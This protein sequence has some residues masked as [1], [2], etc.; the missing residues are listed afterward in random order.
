MVF[1]WTTDRCER[2]NIPD[3]PAR[4]FRDASGQVQQ[5]ISHQNNYR[6]VGPDL[7]NV[8]PDCRV[9]MSSDHQGDPA[10]YNDN[11]WIAA[12]YTEDGK[13]I[14]ALVHNEYH[15]ETHPG[16]CPSGEHFP[17]WG[18][19]ITLFRSTD[20]GD[21]F[22]EARTPP[23][24]LVARLP[25]PYQAGS[26]PMGYRTPSNI[27]QGQDGFFYSFFNVVM[28]DTQ[29]QFLCLMRT[30]DLANPDSWRFWNGRGFSGTFID[31][32]QKTPD[33]PQAHHCSPL[34]QDAIGHA[35][36]NS[37]T[38]NTFL[39]RYVLI[40]LSADHIEGREVWGIYYSF[41]ENL[42]D[43]THRKLL[44]EVPLPWTVEHAGSDLSILYPSLLDP[45]SDSR[46]FETAGKT[47][48]LYYT[49]NNKGHESLDRDLIRVP[50]EFFPE[51]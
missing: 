12:V 48:Y 27:I 23:D 25:Y 16:Q 44:K 19:S 50:V 22:Q 28:P 8:S 7:N 38:Y 40:G 45:E 17:C 32:Y 21:T 34:D 33:N 36:N 31:P 14:H 9:V 43:W 30:D 41:S 18:N 6:L 26:G 13:T 15:G 37:I 35:L 3:L 4:A 29:E 1:D 11:E 47:A 42:V 10:L 24:H 20:G 2:S 46:N 39:E 5:I 49:R 51:P